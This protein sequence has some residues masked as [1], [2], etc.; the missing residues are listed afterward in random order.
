MDRLLSLLD[1]QWFAEQQPRLDGL[2]LARVWGLAL[3]ERNKKLTRQV[4]DCDLFSL[5]WEALN[6]CIPRFNPDHPPRSGEPDRRLIADRFL[7]F[8]R[9]KLEW[10]LKRYAERLWKLRSD[11]GRPGDV[12]FR[13]HQGWEYGGAVGD[14]SQ[15]EL[16]GILHSAIRRLSAEER[17][18]VRLRYWEDFSFEKIAAQLR[19]ADRYLAQRKHDKAIKRLRV[20][21]QWE[22]GDRAERR[23]A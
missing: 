13:G 3:H 17:V 6:Y 8:F 7:G 2:Q 18:I 10:E 19:L 22:M 16:E 20:I 14:R 11:E 12:L 5:V 1:L 4:S 15:E 9:R 21:M 23:A